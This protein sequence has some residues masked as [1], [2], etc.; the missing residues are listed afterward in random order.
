MAIE[1]DADRAVFFNADEHGVAATYDGGTIN[2][3]FG[4][5]HLE[6]DGGG[7]VAF[8]VT[9]PRFQCRTS[10]VSSAAEGDAITINATSYVIKVV[11][12]D[13]TG[14]TTLVLEEQ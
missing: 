7:T 10:D 14:M 11:Q 4:N 1:T 6:L 8:A 12:D 9:Q 5:Q 2:G 3:I 13:G